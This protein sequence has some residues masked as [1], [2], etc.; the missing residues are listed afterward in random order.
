MVFDCAVVYI[1]HGLRHTFIRQ[2]FD[3][4]VYTEAFALGAFP[5]ISQLK[6][7]NIHFDSDGLDLKGIF[8]FFASL[9]AMSIYLYINGA[10]PKTVLY[11]LPAW[12]WFIITAFILALLYFGMFIYTRSSVSQGR[13]KWPIIFNFIL[14]LALFSNLT[15]GFGLLR[16]LQ[17]NYMFTG[18]IVD[19]ISNKELKGAKIIVKSIDEMECYASDASKDDG[20][21]LLVIEKTDFPR[22]NRFTVTLDGYNEK[23]RTLNFPLELEEDLKQIEL[24]EEM[25]LEPP[26]SRQLENSVEDSMSMEL[27]PDE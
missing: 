16:I 22:C 23:H 21:F 2:M 13:M 19:K 12:Y 10:L 27:Q 14:Y 3:W 17:E 25:D 11:Y 20:S 5:W 7:L 8:N 18:K 15:S 26:V 6:K 4:Q 24:E 1:A 9:F